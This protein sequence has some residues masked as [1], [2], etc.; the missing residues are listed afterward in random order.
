MTSLQSKREAI[1][2]AHVAA[3]NAHDVSATLLTFTSPRY[4]VV[5]FGGATDGAEPVGNLLT[6]L[7]AAFPD[8]HADVASLYHADNCVILE[9]R[10]TGTQQGPW[11]GIPPTGKTM[12]VMTACFFL[13]EEDRLVCERV[14]F[15]NATMMRQLG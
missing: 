8:F 10:L 9:V 7:F 13:F 1:V 4:E 3:E 6:A 15:D 2:R 5:P 12:D 14:Y 11:L